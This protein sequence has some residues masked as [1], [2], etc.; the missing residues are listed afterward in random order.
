MLTHLTEA[1][2]T[3]QSAAKDVESRVSCKR[4]LERLSK[5]E[6]L[7]CCVLFPL[8]SVCPPHLTYTLQMRIVP[9]LSYARSLEARQHSLLPTWQWPT[10]L[11]FWTW[12]VVH[13]YSFIRYNYYGGAAWQSVI[14]WILNKS[15]GE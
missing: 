9:S 8:L 6:E 15:V 3:G 13:I 14:L 2:V 4:A 5:A 10:W 11:M 7:Q 1:F 12:L